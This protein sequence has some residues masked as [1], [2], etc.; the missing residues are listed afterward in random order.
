MLLRVKWALKL[1][2]KMTA[3]REETYT[4]LLF[5]IICQFLFLMWLFKILLCM[6]KGNSSWAAK[7]LGA[8]YNFMCFDENGHK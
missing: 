3:P 1:L 2:N 7:G 6:L 5:R 8:L 4:K